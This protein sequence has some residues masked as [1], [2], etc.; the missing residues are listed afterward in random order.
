MRINSHRPPVQ[1][2]QVETGLGAASVE[3][4]ECENEDQLCERDLR[5]AVCSLRSTA[6]NPVLHMASL[7]NTLRQTNDETRPLGYWPLSLRIL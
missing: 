1:T 4:E 5:D 6:E 3:D 7:A 2:C